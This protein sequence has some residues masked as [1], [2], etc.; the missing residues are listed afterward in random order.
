[1]MLPTKFRSIWPSGFWGDDFLEITQSE[2]RISF[3]GHVH[4]RHKPFLFLIGW[5]LKNLLLCNRCAKWI[6]IWKVLYK[7]CSF[8]SDPLTYIWPPQ[9]ILVSD[10]LIQ[11]I[12]N[13]NCLWRPYLLAE[14]DEMKKLYRGPYID[15]FCQ[16]WYHLVQLYR[17]SYFLEWGT[18]P[19]QYGIVPVTLA[20][21]LLIKFLAHL[22][23]RVKW[24]I[25]IT[26]RPSSVC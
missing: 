1:M 4:G 11:P 15:A 17:L 9:A 12:R 5:F 7:D 13:K 2:T 6:E 14:W 21:A 10:W 25:A 26:W 20:L 16:V 18:L 24:G 8:N 19:W 22:T 23:Q 3:G